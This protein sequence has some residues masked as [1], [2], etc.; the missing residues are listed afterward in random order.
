MSRFTGRS[1]IWGLSDQHD[2]R[3][4]DALTGR[5]AGGMSFQLISPPPLMHQT[6]KPSRV[7]PTAIIISAL[8]L[9]SLVTYFMYKSS[10]KTVQ[11][12]RSTESEVL[13]QVLEN[14]G[15]WC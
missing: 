12:V 4:G 11:L 15:G 14:H 9:F 13:A 2:Q 10:A 5:R 7:S 8:L 3:E 6:K 1:R